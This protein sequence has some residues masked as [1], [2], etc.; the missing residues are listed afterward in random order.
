MGIRVKKI[1]TKR[2]ITGSENF[3]FRLRECT[4][5]YSLTGYRPQGLQCLLKTFSF[6]SSVEGISGRVIGC[7][8]MAI[9]AF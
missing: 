1:F 9:W 8:G 6:E 5:L 2:L 3:I 7:V 4:R